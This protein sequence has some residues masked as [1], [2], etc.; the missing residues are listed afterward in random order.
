MDRDIENLCKAVNRLKALSKSLDGVPPKL[1][2]A[3]S[4]AA[5]LSDKVL[6]DLKKKNN[7]KKIPKKAIKKAKAEMEPML[8]G[9]R[10]FFSEEDY[11]V[12]K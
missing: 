5:K 12:S 6:A 3:V 1:M 2:K 4:S 8:F 10:Q 9:V 7:K 11:E